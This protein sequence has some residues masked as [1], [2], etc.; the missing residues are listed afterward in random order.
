LAGVSPAATTP[1]H[2]GLAGVSPAATTPDL[3]AESGTPSYPLSWGV[4]Y[5]IRDAN[6]SD[7]IGRLLSAIKNPA[8]PAGF[9]L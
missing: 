8:L 9:S 1:D 2:I 5:K 4:K 7:K 3:P 6:L